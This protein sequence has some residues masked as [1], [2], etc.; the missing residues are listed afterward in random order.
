M[1]G[2]AASHTPGNNQY[3]NADFIVDST[4]IDYEHNTQLFFGLNDN[5][6]WFRSRVSQ[7]QG[8]T[9]WKRLAYAD[10]IVGSD[11]PSEPDETIPG[12][13]DGTQT[14]TIVDV[15]SGTENTED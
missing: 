15:D 7:T 1:S 11:V 9:A 8:W 13:S 3:A 14:G 2:T 12:D 4:F 5:Y 10:E 6:I